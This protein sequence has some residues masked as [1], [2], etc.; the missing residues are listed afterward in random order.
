MPVGRFDW[1]RPLGL[2]G[3]DHLAFADP[4][5]KIAVV[6]TGTIRVLVVAFETRLKAAVSKTDVV[7]TEVRRFW[8]EYLLM[9]SSNSSVLDLALA[10]IRTYSN[11]SLESAHWRRGTKDFLK[12]RM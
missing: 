1:N 9:R 10:D 8:K 6:C 2:I 7:T 11:S 12:K 3:I 4:E 5:E